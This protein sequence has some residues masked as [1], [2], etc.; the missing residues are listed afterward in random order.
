MKKTIAVLVLGLMFVVGPGLQE[1]NANPIAD[2]E[3]ALVGGTLIFGR[4]GDSITLDPAQLTDGES[5]KVCDMLYDTLIQYRDDT[6]EIAPALAET[7]ESSADGLTWT[8]YLRQ[9]VQF[10]DGTPFDADAVVF[11]LSR[12]NT[13]FRDFHAEF[14]N[15]ITAL[16]AYTVQIQLKKSYAPFISTLAGTSYSIVSPVAVQH[17]GDSFGDVNAVG[18][19]P[20]KFAQ[21]DK[22]DRVVLEANENHWAGRPALD[23]FIFRSIPDNSDRLMELQAGNIHAMEFPNPDEIPLIEGDSQLELIRQSS[24]NVGYLAMNFDK[25]PF[26]N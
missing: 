18:T 21:W 25:P 16:N 10:H 11:S 24:L 3:S 17:Y 15:Q 14:I 7:W 6:T 19:G 2:G 1:I 20:F 23:R 22:G 12:P 8:F 26:D 9:G 5:A 4:G 13:V